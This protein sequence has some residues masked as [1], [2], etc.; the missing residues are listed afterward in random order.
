MR[1][2]I[3]CVLTPQRGGIEASAR[4]LSLAGYGSDERS[5]IDSLRRGVRA[6]VIGLRS[7]GFD[8]E[9]ALRRH[10]IEWED[11]PGETDVQVVAVQ[12]SGA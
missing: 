8:V 7:G 10:A 12:P 4:E 2:T 5:A 3:E 9:Q 11:G 1:I 6:W